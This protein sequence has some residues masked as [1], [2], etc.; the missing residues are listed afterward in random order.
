MVDNIDETSDGTELLL[1]S[2]SRLVRAKAVTAFLPTRPVTVAAYELRAS[3]WGCRLLFSTTCTVTV[4][5]FSKVPV[6]EGSVQIVQMGAGQVTLVATSPATINTPETLKTA[7]QYATA[8]LTC[9]AADTFMLAG[10]LEA[11]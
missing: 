7:K 5:A 1:N 8:V 2:R 4:P 3:D 9:D 6:S 11:A 10:Y